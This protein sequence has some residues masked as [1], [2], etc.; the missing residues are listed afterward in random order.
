MGYTKVL[1]YGQFI[2]I[3]NYSKDV[4]KKEVR[5]VA[6]RA[7]HQYSSSDFRSSAS[8]HRARQAF[9]RRVQAQLYSK[10]VP[11]FVT[12]TNF[13]NVDLSIGYA[14]LRTFIRTIRKRYSGLSYYAV[15]EWQKTGRLH[16]HLLVW[17]VQHEEAERER[18][19]RFFQRCW[20]RGFVDVCNAQD[21]S[22]FLALYLAKYLTKASK[23]RRLLNQRAYTSSH[24]VDKVYKTGSNSLSHL[25]SDIVPLD[26][27]ILVEHT[28][29]TKYLGQ[30]TFTKLEVLKY[31][32]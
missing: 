32:N 26:S 9:I 18:D 8:L 5:A 25:L 4:H 19:T 29:E 11:T 15:P 7:K 1:Q 28:Y 14:Y 6:R 12:L 17:G 2:E 27:R 21:S 16:F 24:N 30:C 10:G 23:D 20:A 31:D 22:V 3:S 13:Q